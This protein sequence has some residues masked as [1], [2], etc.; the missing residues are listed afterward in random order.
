MLPVALPV[1]PKVEPKVEPRVE[2]KPSPA[3]GNP[4][5]TRGPALAEGNAPAAYPEECRRRREE[6]TALI[7]AIVEADGKVSSASIERSSGIEALDKSALVAVLGWM[8]VPALENG[9]PVRSEVNV[10][11]V[12]LMPRAN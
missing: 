8:F 4:G 3:P 12:F 1:E 10:P 5:M 2:P 7:H 6:G 11:V 9:Q